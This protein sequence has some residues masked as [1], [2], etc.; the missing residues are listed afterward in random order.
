MNLQGKTVLIT[1]ATDGL[2]KLV[3]THAAE[4][5]A[6]VILHGRIE[7]KGKRVVEEIKSK[8]GHQNLFYYNADFS[9]LAEVKLFSEEVL[10]KHGA[11]HVLINNAAIGGGPK[12]SKQRELSKDGYEL[13][14]AVN[15]LSHFLLTQK[16]LP[17]LIQSAPA[18]VVNVS[19]I[20]QSS[21][22][23]NDIDS[24]KRYDSF[25][26]YA[27]SKLAQIMFGIE[28]AERVKEKNITVNSLHPATLMNT[29]MVH[30]FFGRTSSTVEEGAKAVEYVAFAEETKDVTGVYFNQQEPTKANAQAYD[31]EARKKLWQLS[32]D[33]AKAFL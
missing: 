25:D 9:S 27:K 13:R 22:D 4:A 2:G 17:L 32:E 23:F 20:G 14:F 1:G 11:L 16:L 12:G 15:Y 33:L 26:S 31:M 24:E 18:R 5:G 7:E 30:E 19:S 21:L 29:N 28:L 8:I 10:A 6:T 3:A